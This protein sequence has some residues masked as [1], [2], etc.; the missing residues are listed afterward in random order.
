M[1][2]NLLTW[3]KYLEDINQPCQ[4]DL[5]LFCQKNTSLALEI[6]DNFHAD[7]VP[8]F[9]IGPGWMPLVFDAHKHLSEIDNNYV[10][11]QIKE[12]F[13]GLRYYA[14]PIEEKN[15][16]LFVSVIGDAEARSLSI[17]EICSN[18]AQTRKTNYTYRTLC[19]ICVS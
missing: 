13:G 15:I 19:D 9:C 11:Y 3:N 8:N 5:Y 7:F 14:E 4:T 1:N 6:L 18:P 17:C 2:S 16:Q 10:V 12:K